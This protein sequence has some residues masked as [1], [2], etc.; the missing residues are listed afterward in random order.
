M[1]N[2]K[3][4]VF[5]ISIGN[6]LFLSGRALQRAKKSDYWSLGLLQDA[7]LRLKEE[8]TSPNLG[9]HERQQAIADYYACQRALDGRFPLNCYDAEISGTA[10]ELTKTITL[11]EYTNPL[12]YDL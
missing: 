9:Y 5:G 2:D 12:E 7:D 1:I 8:K 3:K 6:T 11:M 4:H 10:P